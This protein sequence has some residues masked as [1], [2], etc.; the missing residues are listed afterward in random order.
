[1]E[2]KTPN[3]PERNNTPDHTNRQIRLNINDNAKTPGAESTVD[4]PKAP[5]QNR[6][7]W[8]PRVKASIVGSGFPR[9]LT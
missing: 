1:M 5:A 3:P 4:A 8:E 9:G 2:E 7:L 6:L